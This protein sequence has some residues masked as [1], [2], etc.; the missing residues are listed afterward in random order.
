ME[1]TH[2]ESCL[3]I[4]NIALI[5]IVSISS[6]AQQPGD[7]GSGQSFTGKFLVTYREKRGKEK[8]ENGEEKKKNRGREGGK[9]KMEGGEVTNGNFLPGKSISHRVKSGKMTLPPLKSSTL[10]PLY[11]V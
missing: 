11:L 1:I 2:A 6:V 3:F 7:R 5:V 8:Q 10:T 4:A 9:F